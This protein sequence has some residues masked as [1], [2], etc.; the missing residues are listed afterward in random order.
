V[1]SLFQLASPATHLLWTEDDCLYVPGAQGDLSVL[2]NVLQSNKE[3]EKK[4]ESSATTSLPT[5]KSS[6]KTTALEELLDDSDEE[7][8]EKKKESSATTSLPADKSPAKM[9][10]LDELQDLL[11]DSDEEKEKKKKESS[12]TTNVPA[13]KSSTK[14]TALEDLLDDSDEEEEEEKK[15]ESSATTSV[16]AAKSSTKMTALDE[17]QELLDDSDDDVSFSLANKETSSPKPPS[18]HRFRK[19]STAT[20]NDSLSDDEDVDFSQQQQQDDTPHKSNPFVQDEADDYDEQ[21]DQRARGMHRDNNQ[22]EHQVESDTDDVPPTDY[23]RT[24]ASPGQ[25]DDDDDDE[26]EEGMEDYTAMAPYRQAPLVQPPQAA[27]APSSTP[28]DLPRR[29]LCWNHLGTITLIQGARG[30]VEIQFTAQ[31]TRRPISFTDNLGFILGSLG[32]EGAIFATDMASDDNLDEDLAG[33]GLRMDATKAALKKSNSAAG[34]TI[35]FNRYETISAMREKDWY[36]TLPDGER[37]LGCATGEGWAAVMTRYVRRDNSV[38]VTLRRLVCPFQLTHASYFYFTQPTILTSLLLGRQPRQS[39]L[40]AWRTRHNGRSR[41]I[42]GRLLPR[43]Y[44]SAGWNPK[45]GLPLVRCN[46]QP[47]RCRGLRLLHQFGWIPRVGG[48]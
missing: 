43:Q 21:L 5:A 6:T 32:E 31:A 18:P 42:R 11:D 14:I 13:D 15:K 48:I 16:P 37:A 2:R 47:D 20:N 3:E 35:Y 10:A 39:P 45:A 22:S 1:R 9:T 38:V 40:A 24:A 28:L 33:A 36:L 30:S 25:G 12:A 8:E 7:K 23:Q 41:T 34:S 44:A 17:L 4:K 29:I 46:F 19:I 26:D 27:F